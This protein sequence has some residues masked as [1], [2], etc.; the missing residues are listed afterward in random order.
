M[1]DT[2]Q[3]LVG[4]LDQHDF[5]GVV[6][7][8]T[9]G[10]GPSALSRGLADRANGRPNRP[11]TRFGIA[12]GTKGFTALAVACLIEDGA[13]AA[14]QPI[15]DILGEDLPLVDVRVTVDHLLSHRSGMGDYLDEEKFVDMDE[16]VLDVPVHHL[17]RPSDYLPLIA[18]HPQV[19]E[20]GERFTYNNGAYITLALVVERVA[21]DYHSFV[22]S[23]VLEPAGMIHS[24]FFRSDDLPTDCALGYL[25]DGRVSL[26][27]LPIIGGGDGGAWCSGTDAVS[28]WEG[29][30]AG[31]IVGG[32]TT[33]W[34]TTPVSDL[35]ER[36]YGR[37]FWL[38]DGG[39]V[40]ALEGMDAGISFFTAVSRT[41]GAACAVLSNDSDGAWPIAS[42]VRTWLSSID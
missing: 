4:L 29:L 22:T 35:G 38:E 42:H 30:L 36:Q 19:S 20:P 39:E 6:V 15:R 16:Y 12:S 28:F 40:M 33:R 8:S 10:S 17:E 9:S 3:P 41:T 32:E 13:I 26:F 14:D 5:S 21:G 37:G 25:S 11:T 18:A 1:A 24:G 34:L 23:R 7:T 31:Q 27:H 2:G